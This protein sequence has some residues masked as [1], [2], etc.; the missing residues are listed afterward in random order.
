M[1]DE[2]TALG[3]LE[4]L[5]EGISFIAGYGLRLL[6]IFQ[7]PAQIVDKYGEAAAATFATN[8]G[9][10]V[11]FPPKAS[12]IKTARDISEWLGYQTVKGISESRG[13][14]LFTKKQQSQNTSDQKRAL[15][16]PQEI[17]GLGS[18]SALIVV[19]DCPPIL[20]TRIR[21]YQT[22]IFMDRLKSV[23]PRLAQFG[24]LLPSES[25]LKAIVNSGELAAPVPV[26]DI[27]AH[28]QRV[29][30]TPTEPDSSA[31]PSTK[32]NSRMGIVERPVAASDIP[33]LAKMTLANFTV[34]FSA[35]ERPKAG[36]LN[37]A[38]LHAYA[39]DLCKQAGI[40]L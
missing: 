15:L 31:T 8:H 23:S 17:T 1:M 26:M 6:P 24:R 9:A 35:V 14:G 29:S 40:N 16:L 21:Y 32:G 38:A 36:E 39:D 33:H 28:L 12:E 7:S 37:E 19:E 3:K 34:D 4:C 30:G 25:Q 2:F 11:I 5:A 27:D 18:H 22:P 20:A 13:T 10:Q